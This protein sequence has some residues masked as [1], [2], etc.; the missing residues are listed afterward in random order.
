MGINTW[1]RG[2]ARGGKTSQPGGGDMHDLGD[3]LYFTSDRE[4]AR[5]YAS[6]RAA[7]AGD[8]ASSRVYEVQI[9][10]SKL[11]VLDL[12]RDPRWIRY[13]NEPMTLAGDTTRDLIA[14]N[15]NYGRFF[16]SFLKQHRILL[17]TYDAVIGEEFVRGGNQ[18]CLLLKDGK[19]TALHN[20]VWS[21][22]RLLESGEKVAGGLRRGWDRVCRVF[23][24]SA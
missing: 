12:T 19:R 8:L 18:L 11:R 22:F 3:G 24:K 4:V 14:A 9:D 15:E 5:Q 20:K 10:L 21:S 1:Y 6:L 13:L 23:G 2:E 17:Q 16:G 7:D